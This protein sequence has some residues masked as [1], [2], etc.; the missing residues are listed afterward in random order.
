MKETQTETKFVTQLLGM[1][2]AFLGAIKTYKYA[3]ILPNESVEIPQYE[4]SFLM[5]LVWSYVTK[6][7]DFH[8]K[9]YNPEFLFLKG[10]SCPKKSDNRETIN[11]NQFVN[12]VIQSEEPLKA[13]N[14]CFETCDL[15]AVFYINFNKSTLWWQN[16]KKPILSYFEVKNNSKINIYGKTLSYIYFFTL[17]SI[18]S[19]YLKYND[20]AKIDLYIKLLCIFREKKFQETLKIVQIEFFCLNNE[21][22]TKLDALRKCDDDSFV[23]N[24]AAMLEF[25]D[26]AI[27]ALENIAGSLSNYGQAF[28]DYILSLKASSLSERLLFFPF[29]FRAVICMVLQQER[30]GEVYDVC[31]GSKYENFCYWLKLCIYNEDKQ[32]QDEQEK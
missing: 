6:K 26:N 11:W 28:F 23:D 7:D 19:E 27:N 21:F 24:F 5:Y 18:L 12:N 20:K 10:L 9:D 31:L 2:E 15:H 16:I 3:Y 14:K 13:I 29:D 4:V 22:N 8:I 30:K 32:K 1:T 25:D 17:I